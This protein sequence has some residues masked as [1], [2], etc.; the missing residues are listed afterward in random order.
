MPR[1][2]GIGIGCAVTRC[3]IAVEPLGR[4]S[5]RG[6]RQFKERVV[7]HGVGLDAL[8]RC[9]HAF[10]VLRIEAQGIVV[11]LRHRLQTSVQAYASAEVVEHAVHHFVTAVAVPV[12]PAGHGLG[13]EVEHHELAFLNRVETFRARVLV[14]ALNDP[15]GIGIYL[16]HSR[17]YGG[18]GGR[19][20][21]AA[22][23]A[24]LVEGV[25][26][27]INR[28]A[29]HLLKLLIVERGHFGEMAVGGEQ[30][31][32]ALEL[33]PATGVGDGPAFLGGD[34]VGHHAAIA[35]QHGRHAEFAH[36][37]ED[38]LGKRFLPRVPPVFVR[39][40]PAFEVVHQPPGLEARTGYESIDFRK[41]VAELFEHVF[42][43]YVR[44]NEGERHV[45]AVERHPVDFLLPAFP[46]PKGHGIRECAVVE[47]IAVVGRAGVPLFCAGHGERSGG[48]VGRESVPGEIDVGIMVEIPV[49]AGCN[50]RDA[51]AL[52]AGLAVA[53]GNHEYVF[54]VGR[55]RSVDFGHEACRRACAADAVEQRADGCRIGFFGRCRKEGAKPK[56]EE[57]KDFCFHSILMFSCFLY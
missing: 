28:C 18:V 55:K 49:D 11:T 13:E 2:G 23:V 27:V 19:Q 20:V 54:A 32:G 17:L 37:G 39:S 12:F 56:R 8:G 57:E 48:E 44:A 14:P 46:R 10:E 47:V 4:R 9:A 43:H 42:P 38:I 53:G 26:A 16:I 22:R 29:H 1:L 41:G 51:I 6:P 31:A 5:H 7:K 21:Y 52:N 15:L 36:T 24:A 35:W 45:D 30:E 3:G 40:A 33:A 25:H 50:G 34:V